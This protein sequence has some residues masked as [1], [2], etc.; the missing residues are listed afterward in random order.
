MIVTDVKKHFNIDRWGNDY[1]DINSQGDIVVQTRGATPVALSDIIHEAKKTGVYLPL[2]IQFPDILRSNLQELSGA[3]AKAMQDISY[4]GKYIPAYPIKTNQKSYVIQTLVNTELEEFGLE[5]GSKA[6]FLLTMVNAKKGKTVLICNGIKDSTYIKAALVAHKMGHKVFLVIDRFHELPLVL[7]IAKEM[8]ISPNLGVRVKLSSIKAGQGQHYTG[9]L[10]KFGLSMQQLIQLVNTLKQQNMLASLKML[11]FHMGT[12]LSNIQ[13]IQQGMQEGVQIYK[14]LVNMD[15][16]IT[17]LNVGGGLGVDYTGNN[18]SDANSCNYDI[19]GYARHIVHTL[20]ECCQQNHLPLPDIVT[21]SGRALTAHHSVFVFDVLSVESS[22][23]REKKEYDVSGSHNA[24]IEL[25]NLLQKPERIPAIEVYND[26][27][28]WSL[29]TK[30][31]FTAGDISLPDKAM[32]DSI[33][34]DILADVYQRIEKDNPGH[35]DIQ[36]Y[37]CSLLSSKVT[38]NFSIFRSTPDVWALDQLFPILPIKHLNQDLDASYVISDITCDAD[39]A[40]N[41]YVD[42]QAIKK[43]LNL[44]KGLKTGDSIAIFLVGAY[45][46]I[47]GDNHNLFGLT[48]EIIISLNKEGFSIDANAMGDSVSDVVNYI[49]YDA[50]K[51]QEKLQE[52]I[53]KTDKSNSITNQDMDCLL[54]ILKCYTYLRG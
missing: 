29:Q 14:S 50:D 17:T 11:H 27:I 44:P 5:S 32:A 1:F 37:L 53:N 34:L 54:N 45:Q 7:K 25:H 19:H 33:L 13:K 39:G 41:Y 12:Q 48:N 24:V 36:D 16:E 3:F 8:E 9:E 47:L 28:Y 22:L 10:S 4:T 6:E 18:S 46:D 49:N 31:L 20:F 15:A 26:A 38:G 40:F 30:Q 43:T 35:E 21:E 51:L 2:N 23:P 42:S 52:Q